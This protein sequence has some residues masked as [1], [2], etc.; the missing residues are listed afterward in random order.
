MYRIKTLTIK[1]FTCFLVVGLGACV[2]TTQPESPKTEQ[3]TQATSTADINGEA[4]TPQTSPSPQDGQ[5]K[6]PEPSP[7]AQCEKNE[8]N[9][10]N[11][12]LTESTSC[13]HFTPGA[14]KKGRGTGRCEPQSLPYARCRSGIKT[15]N[16]GNENSPLNWF[17]CEKKI[18][19]TSA[20]PKPGSVLI[21][22]SILK[23][24]M[25]TGHVMYVE[26]VLPLTASRSELILSHTN[27]DRNC[28][29]ETKIKATYNR[30]AMTIDIHTGA[31]KAWGQDLKV[32]GFI[33]R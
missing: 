8:T 24:K 26:S 11:R 29:K 1:V 27:Y 19:N 3:V 21:L 4:S 13:Y 16:L 2:S 18:G 14:K 31:W 33:L 20:D 15:C 30:P 22:G 23:H 17:A 10:P 12:Q 7:N 28:S 9:P 32:A 6:Q 25:K 5:T